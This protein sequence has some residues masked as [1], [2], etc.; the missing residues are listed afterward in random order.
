MKRRECARAERI[1]LEASGF[2]NGSERDLKKTVREAGNI[3]ESESTY[4]N[5]DDHN[6]KG[7]HPPVE[8]PPPSCIVIPS[9]LETH[10]LRLKSHFHVIVGLNHLW[11]HLGFRRQRNK[12]GNDPGEGENESHTE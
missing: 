6:S 9:L 7:D 2:A 4:H 10:Q 1:Q 12:S 8:I 3:L 11:C 5:N